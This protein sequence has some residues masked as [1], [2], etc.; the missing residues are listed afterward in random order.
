MKTDGKLAPINNGFEPR[1]CTECLMLF[2]P[3]NEF[4]T[5]CPKCVASSARSAETRARRLNALGMCE[6]CGIRRSAANSRLCSACG[7][8]Q[9][10][11]RTPAPKRVKAD[12]ANVMK[13]ANAVPLRGIEADGE[14]IPPEVIYMASICGRHTINGRTESKCS[15]CKKAHGDKCLFLETLNRLPY[16]ESTLM[17]MCKKALQYAFGVLAISLEDTDKTL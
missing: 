3:K 1:M 13:S 9:D 5:V 12:P 14:Y 2:N 8:E 16:T 6:K 17:N 7:K 11:K 10:R 15:S 4:H